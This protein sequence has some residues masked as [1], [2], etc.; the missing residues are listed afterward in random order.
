MNLPSP[1]AS[2]RR[3]SLAK[4]KG[5]NIFFSVPCGITI[6]CSLQQVQQQ[7]DDFIA[8][9]QHN[10]DDNP[11]KPHP[12]QAPQSLARLPAVYLMVQSQI[13][14]GSYFTR[15]WGTT[16]KQI[17]LHRFPASFL[18]HSL[19]HSLRGPLHP[20]CCPQGLITLPAS[21]AAVNENDAHQASGTWVKKPRKG[22]RAHFCNHLGVMCYFQTP[23]DNDTQSDTWCHFFKIYFY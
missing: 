4:K 22:C 6:V 1:S 11:Q 2:C 13:T 16:L 5:H 14:R 10:K 9:C 23:S 17:T 19:K 18:M 20:A 3:D 15:R 12:L 8:T 21:Q 7:R